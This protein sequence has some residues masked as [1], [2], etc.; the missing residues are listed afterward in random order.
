MNLNGPSE[1]FIAIPNSHSNTVS[2]QINK[3]AFDFYFDRS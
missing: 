2:L 1:S 3:E